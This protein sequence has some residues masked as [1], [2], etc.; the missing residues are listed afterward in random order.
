MHL[1]ICGTE[2]KVKRNDYRGVMSNY[3]FLL[4]KECS[5]LFISCTA[6]QLINEEGDRQLRSVQ[7][8]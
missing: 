1:S 5:D 2:K 3:C 6:R 4:V 8:V 7:V